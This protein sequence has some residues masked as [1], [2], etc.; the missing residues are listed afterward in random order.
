M[1][2]SE[3]ITWKSFM[4]VP[5]TNL[6]TPWR[7][8]GPSGSP[9]GSGA[10]CLGPPGWALKGTRKTSL[11]ITGGRQLHDDRW[12]FAFFFFSS[13]FYSVSGN[14]FEWKEF[15]TCMSTARQWGSCL[16]KILCL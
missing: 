16:H 2:M 13:K 11:V 1:V 6:L 14:S 12:P 9:G 10:E 3:G 5:S 4:E 8:R 15:I 7:R